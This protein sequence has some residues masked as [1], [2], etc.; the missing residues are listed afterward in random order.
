MKNESLTIAILFA[1][2]AALAVAAVFASRVPPAGTPSYS[3]YPI[4]AVPVEEPSVVSP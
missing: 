4:K 3:S 2:L 1:A